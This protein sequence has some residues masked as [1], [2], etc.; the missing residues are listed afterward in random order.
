MCEELIDDAVASGTT[1][2]KAKELKQRLRRAV[3]TKVGE[4][5]FVCVSS[6]IRMLLA[7]L[8]AMQLIQLFVMKTAPFERQRLLQISRMFTG[9]S[10]TSHHQS[11][12]LATMQYWTTMVFRTAHRET[13][14]CGLIHTQK[15][16]LANR[17]G[18]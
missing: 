11:R 1:Q 17:S 10:T 6:R 9:R 14:R 15:R 8:S 3:M 2:R 4:L 12:S 13:R 16:T 5:Y 7:L 18:Y